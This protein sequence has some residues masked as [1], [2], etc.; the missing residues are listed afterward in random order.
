ME[1]RKESVKSA[2]FPLRTAWRVS[3][4]EIALDQRSVIQLPNNCLLFFFFF[5]I[6]SPKISS[7]ATI[8][9]AREQSLPLNGVVW[10]ISTSVL[11][12]LSS[13]YSIFKV[14]VVVKC[15]PV[16]QDGAAIVKA[17][18]GK[19]I[20]ECARQ[21]PHDPLSG[22]R[23]RLYLASPYGCLWGGGW[24]GESFVP[25]TIALPV[26]KHKSRHASLRL[27]ALNTWGALSASGA[28]WFQD[29]PGMFKSLPSVTTTQP[30]Q[31]WWPDQLRSSEWVSSIEIIYLLY[32]FAPTR[33]KNIKSLSLAVI[34]NQKM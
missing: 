11:A 30:D 28:G 6:L 29:K 33:L 7:K 8:I 27:W 16:N 31:V 17:V 21:T 14:Y 22:E 10:L 34:S 9:R 32:R 2:K 24:A 13:H 23:W 12:P 15:Q 26:A 25:R 3:C 19:S 20:L 18:G 4:G 1:W 5:A